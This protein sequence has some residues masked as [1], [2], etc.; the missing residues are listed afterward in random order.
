ML[1][2]INRLA[3]KEIQQPFERISQLAHQVE[4]TFVYAMVKLEIMRELEE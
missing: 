4:S 1:N 2:I 3:I